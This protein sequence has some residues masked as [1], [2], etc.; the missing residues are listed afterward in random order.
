MFLTG[1]IQNSRDAIRYARG[2]ESYTMYA[3]GFD[4]MDRGSFTLLHVYDPWQNSRNVTLSYVLAESSTM[5]P[6]SLSHL[7]FIKV[8]VR[9]VIA[10]STTHVAMICQ[11]GMD[12]TIKDLDKLQLK[13][14][15]EVGPILANKGVRLIDLKLSSIHLL[16]S[17]EFKEIKSKYK[18][19]NLRKHESDKELLRDKAK[20]TI[21]AGE[22]YMRAWGNT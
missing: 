16:D 2:E 5:V 10:L 20:H 18:R 6:D 15:N 3:R 21:G 19:I 14:Y 17:V 8:P 11:L 7:P 9:R 13:M 1:C 4:M 22:T 12:E